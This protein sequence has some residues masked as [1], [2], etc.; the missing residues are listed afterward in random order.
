MYARHAGDYERI[1][2][3]PD[4]LIIELN[5]GNRVLR[6][7]AHPAFTHV[8]YPCP[9]NG[10]GGDSLI[11]L[12]IAGRSVEVVGRFVPLRKRERLAQEIRAHLLA[13]SR[14]K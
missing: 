4:A 14:A 11:G 10:R 6:R 2:V 13:A 9:G 7:E 8:E 5:S 3:T 1:V 12:A